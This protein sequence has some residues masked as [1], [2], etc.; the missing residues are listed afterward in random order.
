MAQALKEQFTDRRTEDMGDRME[1]VVEID[2]TKGEL[3]HTEEA[4]ELQDAKSLYQQASTHSFNKPS[5][6]N[7]LIPDGPQKPNDRPRG[8]PCHYVQI[9]YHVYKKYAHCEERT[10]DNMIEKLCMILP[11]FK[12]VAKQ[13]KTTILNNFEE[14]EYPGDN[15]TILER[16][17]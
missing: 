4:S 9:P 7:E 3:M 5:I 14:I 12:E 13:R 16:E 6:F 1:Q 8:S 2:A 10:H 17:S 15:R 11:H